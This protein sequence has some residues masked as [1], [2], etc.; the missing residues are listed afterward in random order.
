MKEVSRDRIPAFNKLLGMDRVRAGDGEAEIVVEVRQEITNRRGVVHGGLL[1]ALLDSVLGA[2]VIA[3]IAS[4]EW[5][6]TAQLDVQFLEPG[7]GPTLTGRGRLDRRGRRIAM[8]SGEVVDSDGRTVARAHG[9]W[10]V[11]PSR[12]SS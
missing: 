1:T 4:E 5:C 2:A 6:G 10:Y 11:W 7:R 9:T 12:P 8:A 3:G